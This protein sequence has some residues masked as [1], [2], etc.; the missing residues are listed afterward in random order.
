MSLADNSFNN[1][2]NFYNNRI[3]EN[4]ISESVYRDQSAVINFL[5]EVNNLVVTNN[6]PDISLEEQGK[7]DKSKLVIKN[8]WASHPSIQE[9]IKRLEKTGF[10]SDNNLDTLANNIFT[11]ISELQ[12][13]MTN[14]IFEAVCYQGE[15]KIISPDKFIEEFKQETL[16]NSFA[17]DYNGYYDN[18]NPINFDLNESNSIGDRVGYSELYS[19]EMVDLVYSAIAIQ[20][21]T[22][23][24]KCISNNSLSIKT[25]DYDGVRYKRN[26]AD[27]LVGK[28]KAELESINMKIKR[29]DTDVYHFF[30]RLENEQN[31]PEKLEC[32]YKEFFEFDKTYDSKYDIYTQLLNELQFVSVTTPFEL[33]RIN[34]NRIK[35][36]EETLKQEI[37]QLLSN[38]IFTTEITQEIKQNLERY[39]S[40]TW[41]YFGR[42]SYFD[43]HLNLLY[44]SMH[45]YAYL[46]SRK[47]FL[48]KKELLTYQEE[49]I[50]NH[51][52]H[53]LGAME[54]A[55]QI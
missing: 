17:K 38:S 6:L 2:L 26:D 45:N 23:T 9:R 16:S 28:L 25:F 52:Q 42:T 36:Q 53:T 10:L 46:L 30:R 20:N 18:K 1:V 14:K 39:I 43:E 19:N 8:Q 55:A 44:T 33:I 41:E 13:Q 12:K 7:F 24:L 27:G 31:K 37:N 54:T 21:D 35:P 4:I 5:A 32:I 40:K 34:F 22:E 15:A 48:L 51:T 11:D 47:Y 29:N 3:S 49:L 50:K